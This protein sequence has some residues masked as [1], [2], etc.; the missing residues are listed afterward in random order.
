MV[1]VLPMLG[2]ALTHLRMTNDVESWLP[3]HDRD[4]R[5]LAWFKEYFPAEDRVLVTWDGSS[6]HDPRVGKF[7]EKLEG[8]LDEDG[9]RRNGSP[10][11]DSVITAEGMCRKMIEYGVEP[12]EAVRRLTGTLIGYG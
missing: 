12:D 9:V 8:T 5:V 10:L 1:F 11:I 7:A 3:K 6:L 2:L 4:A